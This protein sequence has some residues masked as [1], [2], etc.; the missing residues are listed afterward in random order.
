MP[1]NTIQLQTEYQKLFDTCVIKPEKYVFVDKE[2]QRI[3]DNRKYYDSVEAST[4][5]P[6][7]F[8]G[9]IHGL[10]G[11]GKFNTHLHNGDP[12]T[13]K[14]IQVPKGRPLKGEAPFTWQESARDALIMKKLDKIVTW[15][16]SELLYNL[17]AYNG[18]GYRTKGIYSPYLWSFS[19]QYSKG[20][21]TSDGKYDPNAVSKQV[22][23]A[24]ILRRLAE[25]Q[26]IITGSI[27]RLSQLKELGK[28]VSYNPK[29]YSDNALELQRLLNTMGQFLK[30]DGYAGRNTSDSFFR[31]T[32]K[33]L[34]GDNE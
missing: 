8:V 12:L 15:T 6:W 13:K 3:L 1:K 30:P 28:L 14:T 24:V 21:Y 2:V 31:V 5:V 18:F 27:D 16:I 20:K 29:K 11:G 33:Y 4:K 25:K 9:I 26:I 32:G 22:G 19:N 7:Y 23:A 17:E 34:A 10:E